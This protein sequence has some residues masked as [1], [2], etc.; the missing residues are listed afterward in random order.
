MTATA[1]GQAV[2]V[3]YRLA[4]LA[5]IEQTYEVFIDAANDLYRKNGHAA[6]AGAG[7]PPV[8]AMSFRRAMLRNDP[9]RYWVAEAG[10]RMIGFAMATVREDVWYLAALHVLPEYQAHGVGRE[11]LRRSC[12]GATSA[13]VRTVLS[14]TINPISNALYMKTGMLHQDAILI[15]DGVPSR[16]ALETGPP[17]A[18]RLF[19]LPADLAVVTDLDRRV[20]GY[21]R[22]VDHE[23]WNGI[24]DM[25]GRVLE[26]S[27]EFAGYA[28]ASAAGHL[29]PVAVMD[30]NDLPAALDVAAE[31]ANAAG[32]EALHMRTCGTAR[33]AAAWAL[34]RG[35]RL[36]GIGLL[37]SSQ[38]LG[39]LEGYLTSGGDA[40]F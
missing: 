20:V 15:F 32:A 40:F 11:L 34:A 9:E 33:S 26:S 36:T 35:L 39:R 1:V 23:F 21:G 10:G 4:E 6:E 16:P 28:Y 38:P 18:T 27:G 14:D 5:D 22:A 13:T 17:L 12:V 7:S 19:T 31:M 8:R 25:T 24:D 30:P 3:S 2:E 37:L 29:G